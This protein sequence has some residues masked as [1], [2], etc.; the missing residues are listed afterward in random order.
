MLG[1][2]F[3]G[4]SGDVWAVIGL[5]AGLA[6]VNVAN[7]GNLT[8]RFVKLIGAR[9]HRRPLD[10]KA[11]VLRR[12]V[13]G[14]DEDVAKLRNILQ[15]G[16]S[17]AITPVPAVTGG[18]GVGKTTLA[19]HYSACHAADYDRR[20]FLQA[21]TEDALL[22][23]LA[24]LADRIEGDAPSIPLQQRAIQALQL[25]TAHTRSE[26]WLIVLDN[27]ETPGAVAKW[28]P[29]GRN[30]HLLITS[31]HPDWKGN[32][33]E[34][35]RAGLLSPD[36]SVR[37][38]EQEAGRSDPDM[39]RLAEELGYLPLALVQAG[40]WLAAN[41]RKSAADYMS[42][43]DEYL[44]ER[45][46]DPDREYDRS[47]A[48]V[49]RLTLAGLS[50]DARAVAGILCRFAP[51]EITEDPFAY[52]AR[53][54]WLARFRGYG[55]GVPS[56]VWA[57]GRNPARLE[58]VFSELRLKA[59]L[60]DAGE[61]GGVL[62][63]HRITQRVTRGALGR[64]AMPD[65]AAALLAAVYPSESV[66]S[67]NWPACRRLTPHVRA[68]WASG[69][70]PGTA[71]MDFAAESGVDLS[72]EDRGLCG[73]G[74]DGAGV[75]GADIRAAARDA[76]RHRAG[77]CQSGAGADADRRAGRGRGGIAAGGGAGRGASS[78]QR[79]SGGLV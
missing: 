36:A 30:L 37:L 27:V 69:A 12:K 35:Y 42:R 56:R 13:V 47:T 3:L 34:T 43:L 53:E 7:G 24:N 48:A 67:G 33:Y 46:E 6:G 22:R 65:R 51:D 58:A 61:D 44:D 45:V 54:R 75:A 5:F 16:G 31:R 64:A 4:I 2:T 60:E 14:R 39:S 29:Q 70:A 71:A 40:E 62:R 66:Q 72:G 63:M 17:G 57:I 20:E 38:L 49:V 1:W 52:L 23:D 59:L 21:A 55:R 77:A 50:A 32:V 8:Y 76:S 10:L 15:S 18:G 19:R 78:G 25:V 28:M 9:R 11:H 68:L 74:R 79:R 26:T 73:C 41:R